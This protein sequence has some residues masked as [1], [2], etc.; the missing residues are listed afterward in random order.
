[1][2]HTRMTTLAVILS[3]LSPLD[4]FRCNSVSALYLE[5]PLE[6]NNDTSQLCRT[7]HDDVSCTRMTTLIFMLS[8]LPSLDG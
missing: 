4:G 7:G 6:Y 3:E 2:S 5:D 1:M 8:E